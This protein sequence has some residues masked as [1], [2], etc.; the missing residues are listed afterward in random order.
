MHSLETLCRLNAEQ[1]HR[2][3]TGSIPWTHE[4]NGAFK[5]TDLPSALDW[6]F[7]PGD[8]ERTS[9]TLAETYPAP[10]PIRVPLWIG[11]PALLAG[12]LVLGLSLGILV[13]L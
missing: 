2:E 5:G 9:P 13:S 3:L 4:G 7:I 1:A 10:H 12:L 11:L 8:T 6:R